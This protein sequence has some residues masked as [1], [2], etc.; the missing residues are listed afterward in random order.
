[1]LKTEPRTQE[2]PVV[3][4]TGCSQPIQ[5]A[6]GKVCGAD[7]YLTKPWDAGELMK[8]IKRLASHPKLS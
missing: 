3:M 6:Y 8:I 2:I 4:L 1:L 7:A 5:E